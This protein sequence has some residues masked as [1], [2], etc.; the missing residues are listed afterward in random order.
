MLLDFGDEAEIDAPWAIDDGDLSDLDDETCIPE[1]NVMDFPFPVGSLPGT[2]RDQLKNLVRE[3]FIKK[4]NFQPRQRD[5][6]SS[7][8]SEDSESL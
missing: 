5:G 3:K 6:S 7:C 4:Y 2:R 1:R 8:D